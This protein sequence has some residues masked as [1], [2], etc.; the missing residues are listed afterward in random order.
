[1]YRAFMYERN[2][3]SFVPVCDSR[4]ERVAALDRGAVVEPSGAWIAGEPRGAAAR[5][6][7]RL[8][9]RCHRWRGRCRGWLRCSRRGLRRRGPRRGSR[10]TR[11]RCCCRRSRLL[12]RQSD[13]WQRDRRRWQTKE[14][15]PRRGDQPDVV[16]D[17]RLSLADLPT[18]HV[19][20]ERRPRVLHGVGQAHHRPVGTGQPERR[21]VRCL[22]G[23]VD[24]LVKSQRAGQSRPQPAYPCADLD[25]LALWGGADRVGLV[26][27]HDGRRCGRRQPGRAVTASAGLASRQV[28]QVARGPTSD[29]PLKGAVHDQV[30]PWRGLRCGG[31]GRLLDAFPAHPSRSWSPPWRRSRCWSRRG[32]Q[33][34]ACYSGA[35]PAAVAGAGACVSARCFMDASSRRDPV[36]RPCP[37]ALDAVSPDLL[38]C[39]HTNHDGR[40]AE[41]GF[42]R[43]S[44]EIRRFL[45]RALR[46]VWKG[47]RGRR[48][49][50]AACGSRGPSPRR[51]QGHTPP[52]T[53]SWVPRAAGD[54]PHPGS[55]AALRRNGD[56][57]RPNRRRFGLPKRHSAGVG[58]SMRELVG[59]EPRQV[60]H[61]C[62]PPREIGRRPAQPRRVPHPRP[63]SHG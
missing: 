14:R 4:L 22:P 55:V 58:R 6:R 23:V 49:L 20:I 59:P 32:E 51:H 31:P 12:G 38:A 56:L 17:Q 7:G 18:E 26:I 35:V 54:A 9:R 25:G 57:R 44:R 5:G 40:F 36:I 1:M 62:P 13:G 45:C 48:P 21:P 60:A 28:A 43:R 39:T 46:S 27:E 3:E 10:R 2:S 15:A 50:G 53:G 29:V 11:C 34:G 16:D 41:R 37:R 24:D 42:R 8:R 47:G 61:A 52:R 33:Q 30:L 63:I 19:E